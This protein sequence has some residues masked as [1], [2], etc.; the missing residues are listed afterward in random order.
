MSLCPCKLSKEKKWVNPSVRN[1]LKT[2]DRAKAGFPK[3]FD[4]IRNRYT[5]VSH[6]KQ[7]VSNATSLHLTYSL[8]TLRAKASVFQLFLWSDVAEGSGRRPARLRVSL[9]WCFTPD[10]KYST[11]VTVVQ[12]THCFGLWENVLCSF[13]EQ[14]SLV[15][16]LAT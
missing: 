12:T 5:N 1:D 4:R 15:L 2:D 10:R 7:Q 8:W 3:P 9:C 14:Q 6:S 13:R 11:T 16:S